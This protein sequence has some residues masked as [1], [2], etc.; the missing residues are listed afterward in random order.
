MNIKVEKYKLYHAFAERVENTFLIRAFR[1][2][3][4]AIVSSE[5]IFPWLF[6]ENFWCH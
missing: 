6:V 3:I 1:I 4:L 5:E 2:K